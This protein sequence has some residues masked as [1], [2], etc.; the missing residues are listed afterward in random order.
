MI[1]NPNRDIFGGVPPTFFSPFPSKDSELSKKYSAIAKAAG[2]ASSLL[3][4]G[5]RLLCQQQA[6]AWRDGMALVNFARATTVGDLL[7]VDLPRV[8]WMTKDGPSGLFAKVSFPQTT[9]PDELGKALAKVGLEIAMQAIS[10]VPIVGQILGAVV[11]VAMFVFRM[12]RTPREQE[13]E[14]LLPWEGYS[15][16]VDEDLVEILHKH[17][18]QGVDWTDVFMP[19]Y[20]LAPWSLHKAARD[21]KEFKGGQVW[22][23]LIGDQI[24]YAEGRLGCIPNTVRCAG[25]LQRLPGSAPVAKLVR[26]WFDF[27][28]IEWGGVVTNVGDFF[29]STGQVAG[30]MW[31]QVERRGSAEMYKVDARAIKA[32]W[33]DYFGQFF[34]SGFSLYKQDRSIGELLAPYICTQTTDIRLGIPNMMRPHPAPFVTPDIFKKG[35]GTR[36]TW[37]DCLWLEENLPKKLPDWPHDRPDSKDARLPAQ[38]PDVNLRCPHY[39]DADGLT[40]SRWAD[41]VS[42]G[43]N[44]P[45]VRQPGALGGPGR[46][47]PSGY[48]CVPWPTPQ[49]RLTGYRPPDEAI[50][51][52]ACDHVA[53]MQLRCLER[54]LISAYVRP[55]AVGDLPA[56]GAFR[57]DKALRDRCIE[58]RKALLAHEDR[59]KVVLKDVKDIDPEFERA[60]RDTGVNNSLAQMSKHLGLSAAKPRDDGTPDPPPPAVAGGLPFAEVPR[61][62]ERRD[63]RKGLAIAGGTAAVAGAAYYWSKRRSRVPVADT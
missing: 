3:S 39:R 23:P 56:Y 17:F 14:L 7:S 50:I 30:G 63:L 38:H 62:D 53:A 8:A 41:A 34:D 58:V 36:E 42:T 10:S 44:N 4:I 24:P 28:E 31:K 21:G 16:T 32:A 25:H 48:R 26:H 45:G 57:E 15:D 59:F 43:G 27:G 37:I 12:F 1:Q 19:P 54:T 51:G 46:K 61:S 49:E 5:E 60:L 11:Q 20:E 55:M 40:A 52:P 13:P 22:A 35:P 33:A 18:A 6:Q 47:P 9:D 29:P 2:D